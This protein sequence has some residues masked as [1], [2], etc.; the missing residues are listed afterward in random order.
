MA[1]MPILISV[2]KSTLLGMGLNKYLLVS[3]SSTHFSVLLLLLLLLLQV[4]LPILSLCL[5]FLHH[6]LCPGRPDRMDLISGLPSS[7]TSNWVQTLG[8]YLEIEGR[9]WSEV[10]V[11][12]LPA[13]SLNSFLPAKFPLVD[14]LSW[15]RSMVPIGRLHASHN[16]CTFCG[17]WDKM[18]S[19][20]KYTAI[21]LISIYVYYKLLL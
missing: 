20:L 16:Y 8:L 1:L 6:A 11:F 3:A 13:P 15:F 4:Y 17:L 14:Y 18:D 12:F 2:S 7:L 19:Y 10:W 9:K 21:I 5:V